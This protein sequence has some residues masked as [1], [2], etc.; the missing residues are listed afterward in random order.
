MKKVKLAMAGL[1]MVGTLLIVGCS[2]SVSA[3]DLDR[4]LDVT[5]DTLYSFEGSAS[6]ANDE[7]A[8]T[9]FASTL[10]SNMNAANPKVHADPVGIEMKQ[11]GS[12]LG[13]QD[14]NMNST[15]DA[16]EKDLFTVEID[17][18][19][20]RLIATDTTGTSRD[21]RFS[22]TGLLAGFILGSLLNR[23][24]AAGINKSALS[25]KKV[26]SRSAYQSARSRAGSG[27][28]SS[29]K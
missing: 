9:A 2:S 29:G 26:T 3:P 11:D 25:N 8:I 13:Y 28:H 22:G 10:Q 23:Q 6:N 17:S 16:D 1:S 19:N 14:V 12:I 5:A 7:S 15:K 20:N 18:E 24:T 21:H 27:S 4:V